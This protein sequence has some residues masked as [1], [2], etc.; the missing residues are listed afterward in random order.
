MDLRTA[1]IALSLGRAAIGTGL[2]LAPE[3][4]AKGWVGPGGAGAPAA[5]LARSVGVRD[6]VLGAG[7]ALSLLHDDDSAAA[8]LAGAALCDLGDVAATLIAR[9]SLPANGVRGT[10]ALA[11]GSAVIASLAALA[12]R[13]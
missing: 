7:G 12:A 1:A 2:L 4:I 10:L 3:P 9:D 5:T 13:S 8:W 11:G 6:L